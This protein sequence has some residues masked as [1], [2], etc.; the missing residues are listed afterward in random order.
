MCPLCELGWENEVLTCSLLTQQNTSSNPHDRTPT[1]TSKTMRNRRLGLGR[2]GGASSLLTRAM[3]L[4]TI[5]R[6]VTV[7]VRSMCSYLTHSF[8]TSNHNECM[9]NTLYTMDAPEYCNA[10]T[11][12][13]RRMEMTYC[14]QSTPIKVLAS[15]GDVD[16][17]LFT[18]DVARKDNPPDSGPS[19]VQDL[20][21]KGGRS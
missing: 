2:P 9:H 4:G 13:A 1:S 18:T 16:D 15:F 20:T 11:D 14:C 21:R 5:R 8:H 7:H 19:A 12:S 3:H 10:D 6:A 17:D